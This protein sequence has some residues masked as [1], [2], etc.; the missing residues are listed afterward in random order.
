MD[1]ISEFLTR[2]RNAGK[3][4]H[5]K[6]D[7]PS[8][9]MRVGIAN[10]L[11]ERGY[12]RSFKVVRDGKQGIMRIY[13]KYTDRGD[14]AIKN[15]QRVSR[16]GCRVYVGADGVPKVRS[17]YG[18]AVLS[19]PQGIVSGDTATQKRIGGELLCKVW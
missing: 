11:Q 10:I 7:V 4:G 19:T 6:V 3:A 17:G 18:I 8:S 9:N 13:L 5:E 14:H 1:T 12:I 2:I 15:L 16:P